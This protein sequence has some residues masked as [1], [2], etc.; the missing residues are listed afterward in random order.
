MAVGE[1]GRPKGTKVVNELKTELVELRKSQADTQKML[2]NLVAALGEASR[3]QGKEAGDEP[4]EPSDVEIT[5]QADYLP[6]N[7]RM[8]YEL[9]DAARASSDEASARAEHILGDL[10]QRVDNHAETASR[11]LSDIEDKVTELVT[12]A[13]QAQEAQ[14]LARQQAQTQADTRP[15]PGMPRPNDPRFPHRPYDDLAPSDEPQGPDI[16]E[17][18]EEWTK[19]IASLAMNISDRVEALSKELAEAQVPRPPEPAPE[20]PEPAR[21]TLHPL[22]VPALAGLAAALSAATLVATLM[23]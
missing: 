5:R 8:I 17:E 6:P 12:A 22:V 13:V 7:F 20:P 11:Q 4:V 23:G 10:S 2:E 9:V 15:R 1:Q 3:H 14:D 18:L 19:K 16:S 21:P